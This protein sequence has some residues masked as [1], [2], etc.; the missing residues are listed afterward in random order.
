MERG[1]AH[2]DE[3]GASAWFGFVVFDGAM[4][5]ATFAYEQFACPRW[6]TCVKP[7]SCVV[8]VS[9]GLSGGS[10]GGVVHVGDGARVGDGA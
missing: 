3:V 5:V 1:F 9:G 6:F 4:S 7:S 10:V 2:S 8:G